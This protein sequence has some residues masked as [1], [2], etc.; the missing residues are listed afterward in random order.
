MTLFL[1]RMYLPRLKWVSV[2]GTGRAFA[3]MAVVTPH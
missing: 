3:N 2:L 1:I